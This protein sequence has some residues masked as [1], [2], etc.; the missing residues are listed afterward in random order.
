[1]KKLQTLIVCIIVATA[2]S[3]EADPLKYALEQSGTNRQEWEKVLAHYSQSPADTL[4]YQAA[5]FLISNMP[6]HY[7]YFKVS[8][9]D[10]E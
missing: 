4:K 5:V 10:C 9:G 7:W 8:A 1:M 3:N 6:G 2:C